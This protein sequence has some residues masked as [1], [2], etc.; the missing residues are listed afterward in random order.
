[1]KFEYTRYKWNKYRWKK[2]TSHSSQSYLKIQK[3]FFTPFRGCTGTLNELT[4]MRDRVTFYSHSR[5]GVFNNYVNILTSTF[6]DNLCWRSGSKRKYISHRRSSDFTF[7][8]HKGTNFRSG[9]VESS[10]NDTPRG[11]L[12]LSL[13]YPVILYSPY[14][15]IPT[16]VSC[17]C[18]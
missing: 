5:P 3:P 13:L 4:W 15:K 9:G 16:P 17:F 1:M 7:Y 11:S 2:R 12:W 10:Q 8:E 18:N 14:F 6:T